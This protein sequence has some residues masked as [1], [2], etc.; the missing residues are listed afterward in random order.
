VGF[1]RKYTISSS[2]EIKKVIENGIKFQAGPLKIH[3]LQTR[4]NS[5]N[6]TAFAVPR[7]GRTVVARNRLK[8]RLQE[9]VR[10]YPIQS[11]GCLTVVRVSSACYEYTFRQLEKRY[12]SLAEKIN[13]EHTRSRPA[14][15]QAN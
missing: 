5:P 10:L 3:L 1:P 4:T 9:L 11:A 2:R 8:R 13:L 14:V 7:C 12:C 15:Q 6:R